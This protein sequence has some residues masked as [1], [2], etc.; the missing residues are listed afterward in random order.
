MRKAAGLWA[1][2]AVWF[3]AAGP[4]FALN[5][6]GLY[7]GAGVGDSTVR[8]DDDFGPGYPGDFRD[9]HTAWKA[10]VGV[11]PIS[12]V[13]AELEYID[14]GHASSAAAYTYGSYV[15][16]PTN[17]STHPRAGVLF[18]VGYLPLPMPFIDVYGKLGVA[19]LDTSVNGTAQS[20]CTGV[21]CTSCLPGCSTFPFQRTQWT[22]NLA[23]GGGVQTKVL[24]I[25]FRAEYER[26]SSS[27]GD[28][29]VF[30]ISAIWTF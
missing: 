21:A 25:A 12:L 1:V 7:A 14:F 6:L 8:S 19:R 2:A 13:G 5:P 3:C 29:D 16:G 9:H 23:Y 11:R 28:P 4:V 22:T 27:Y 20:A 10:I 17:A 26:I 18:A 24:G 15:Y 30:S